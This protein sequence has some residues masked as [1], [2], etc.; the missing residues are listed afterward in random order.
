[1]YYFVN[2][3]DKIASLWDS[4]QLSLQVKVKAMLKF[5]LKKGKYLTAGPLLALVLLGCSEPEVL[6]EQVARPMPVFQVSGSRVE[7]RTFVGRAKAVREVNLAARVP[8]PLVK[9]PVNVG[10]TVTAGQVLAVIDQQD[11]ETALKAAEG[12][13]DQVQSEQ[14][15]AQREYQR[16]IDIKSNNPELIS[17]SQMDMAQRNLKSANAA[18]VQA[19]ASVKQARDSLAYTEIKA[20]FDGQVTAV[21]AENFEEIAPKQV[22][23]RVLDNSRIE[24]VVDIPEQLIS[25]VNRVDNVQVRFDAFSNSVLSAEIKEV[26]AEADAITR[27]YP[28]TLVMDQVSGVNI[29]PGMAGRASGKVKK[30][31]ADEGALI[32]VKALG[33]NTDGSMFIWKVN[34]NG[35][36]QKMNLESASIDGKGVLIK[37]PIEAGDQIALAGIYQVKEGQIVKPYVAGE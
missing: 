1:M 4:C 26:G 31:N 32:P 15:F 35:A 6:K 23:V 2:L 33:Q 29:L 17:P 19:K 9:L 18:L 13:L 28:I 34:P 7:E 37:G 14:E 11:Y 3:V 22:V 27:T 21:L 8:G 16:A 10:D 24:M 36:L 25:S 5:A 30:L 12:R 20:P